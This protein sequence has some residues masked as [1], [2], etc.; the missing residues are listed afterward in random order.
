M[1]LHTLG[2]T[3]L[4]AA[5][6]RLATTG[7]NIA[8]ADT[9]GYNRQSVR[10]STAGG[11]ATVNGFVGRGVQ[12]DAVTR[13]Y[14]SFLYRQL[15]S[16]QSSGAALVAH[17]HQL[18]QIDSVLA[19]HDVGITPALKRFFD[20]ID[21][22]A[23]SPADP[24]ARQDLIG[25][26]SSLAT[27]M[28]ELGAF[29]SRQSEDVNR[30]IDTTVAQ[31]NSHVARIADLNKQIAAAKAS[32]NQQPPND[33]YDQRDQI[34]A[35]LNQLVDVRVV[36]QDDMYS[37]SV[38][39]GQ[40]LLS[41]ETAFPL[42][43]VTSASD[44]TRLAVAVSVPTTTPG[45]MRPL[46]LADDVIAG[47]ALGGLLQ[48]RRESLTPLQNDLGK[49]AVGLAQAFNNLHR[50]GLDLHGKAGEDFFTLAPAEGVP[51]TGNTGSAQI[52]VDYAD[53]N[54]MTGNDYQVAFA[55]GEYT[56]TRLPG[57]SVAYHGPAADGIAI[58]GLKLN[59]SGTPQSGDK[60]LL[61]PTRDAAKGLKVAITD[62]AKVA[63]ADTKGGTA[64][65]EIA[66]ELAKLRSQKVMGNG[67]VSLS[68]AYSQLV[69][70]GAVKT[71][72]IGHA[73]K[74]AANLIRL[75]YEKQQAVS[76]VNL[77]EEYVNI[78]RYQEQFRA[79]AQVIDAGTKMFDTL[80]G[81][82]Q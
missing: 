68:E 34:V 49:M 32:G 25:Q 63:A 52:K 18:G 76:G 9:E 35:E 75:S 59:L 16:A 60:W 80:L 17:G 14:D 44:P 53:I 82:R 33:L 12:V 61:Q 71:Q 28:N 42:Q 48:F 79:A 41:G 29:L 31:V 2:L 46:E 21:A 23:S 66:L 37:L 39:R 8:N 47:G 4:A 54:A 58:D 30:Q 65:G 15:T 78:E 7:H 62:P 22:V 67:T 50:Q 13:S 51:N 77:N 10:V 40:V 38:G 24:A 74:A 11:Q 73:A 64:N 81:L 43:A 3:G 6:A 56:V 72:E 27:Q 36:A 5:Q 69:N 57:N 45:V 1:N 19:D 20:S 26:A 55:N 70:K